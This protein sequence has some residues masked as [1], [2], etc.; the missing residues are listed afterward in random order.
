MMG[1][2][3]RPKSDRQHGTRAGYDAGCRCGPCKKAEAAAR[4]A[5]RRQLT[6]TGL[7]AGDPR[8]GTTMAYHQ[9]RCR[10]EVCVTA[11]RGRDAERKK[12]GLAVGDTRHGTYPGYLTWGCRCIA[13]KDAA[14]VYRRSRRQGL[15]DGDPRHGTATGHVYWG[16]RCTACRE[17][18]QREAEARG[19]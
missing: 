5:N 13:C 1:F 15:P 10:C 9:Y 8:H 2:V 16:C 7:A 18:R 14:S 19:L 17:W 6:E 11:K 4:K 3:T 12:V